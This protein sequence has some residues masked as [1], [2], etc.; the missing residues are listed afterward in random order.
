MRED[1][2]TGQFILPQ[3]LNNLRS[4]ETGFTFDLP[5]ILR[6]ISGDSGG[7]ARALGRV[8]PFDVTRRIGGDLVDLFRAERGSDPEELP[9]L[10]EA[11]IAPTEEEALAVARPYLAPKYEAYVN[12]GQSD[13]LPPTDTLRREWDER[14]CPALTRVPFHRYVGV[15]DCKPAPCRQCITTRFPF[16]TLRTPGPT[17]S[18][19]A[20]PS[21]PSR[22]GRNL[23]DPFAPSISLICAPQMPL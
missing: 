8:R 17:S 22:C 11:C 14:R 20:D 19:V 13:V 21:W 10:R 3:T 18:T 5:R 4:W 7:I 16:L 1:A 23:S 12:W 6:G 15:S 9:M 2:D